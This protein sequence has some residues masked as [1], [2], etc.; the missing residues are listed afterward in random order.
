VSTSYCLQRGGAVLVVCVAV[1]RSGYQHHHP[2][3]YLSVSGYSGGA[4]NEE[5]IH[6]DAFVVCESLAEEVC[7]IIIYHDRGFHPP[8]E[9][10]SCWL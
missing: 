3:S 6:I 1:A 4:G 7:L 9:V 10:A 5:L 8:V 2:F